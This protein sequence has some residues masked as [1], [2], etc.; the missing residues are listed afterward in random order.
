MFDQETLDE[1]Y[2]KR[3]IDEL[4]TNSENSG[5][6]RV[7]SKDEIGPDKPPIKYARRNFF[8]IALIRG[9]HLFHYADKTLEV[10]GDTLVFSNPEIPYTFESIKEEGGGYFCIFKESFFSEY[11][12]DGLRKLPMYKMGGSPAFILDKQ[13]SDKVIVVFEKMVEEINS[14]YEFKYDLIRNYVTE[15]IHI[16]LKLKPSEKLYPH[17]DANTRITNVFMELLER[18]F[19]IEDSSHQFNMKSAKDFAEQLSIHVNHLNRAVKNTTGKTTSEIIYERI[20]SEAKALLKHTE[21]NVAEI[22]FS[23]G[24]ED[25]TH[26]NHFFKRHTNSKPSDYRV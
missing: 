19:P 18:Q 9:H 8:K 26:F 6:I 20:I 17:T 16:A 10:S 13:S 5:H 3:N 14:D 1:F 2:K 4:N 25:P 23:L 21:W 7:F 24:F 22:G 12:R 11:L 15:I